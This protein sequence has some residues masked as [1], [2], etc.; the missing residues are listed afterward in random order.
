M[1]EEAVPAPTGG[2]SLNVGQISQIETEFN[3]VYLDTTESLQT[4]DRLFATLQTGEEVALKVLK[5]YPV[6]NGAIAEVLE[7]GKTPILKVQDPV[8]IR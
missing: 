4:G 7:P 5:T 1:R 8:F 2:A 6:L 3:R